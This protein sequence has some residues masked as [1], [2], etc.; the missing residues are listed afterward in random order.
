ML[1]LGKCCLRLFLLG[2][3]REQPSL[4]Q[5]QLRAGLLCRLRAR[6]YCS[7]GLINLIDSHKLALKKWFNATEIISGVCKFSVGS[8]DG[9]LCIGYVRFGLLDCRRCSIQTCF[10][11]EIQGFG[12]IHAIHQRR[13]RTPLIADLTMERIKVGLSLCQGVCVWAVVDL[14]QWLALADELVV[15]N[16]EA[17]DRTIDNRCN[18]DEICEKFS[19][20]SSGIDDCFVQDDGPTNERVEH[21]AHAK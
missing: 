15:H 8:P 3:R 7:S 9:R 13:D 16:M 4:S 20:I 21:D 18:S 14:K 10:G 6:I 11:T 1:G 17:S 19:V 2:F 5:R 12:N